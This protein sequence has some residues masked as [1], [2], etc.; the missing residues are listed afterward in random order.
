MVW[1]IAQRPG[2]Y[3][4]SRYFNQAEQD[5]LTVRLVTYIGVKPKHADYLN[6]HDIE[7]RPFYRKQAES[8][9]FHKL[10][11]STDGR[12]FF[13][14]IRPARH[15]I[16]EK[17]AIGGWIIADNTLNIID[18]EEVF[19]TFAMEEGKLK[20]HSANLFLQLIKEETLTNTTV[21]QLIE[22]PD[23]R[24]RYDKTRHEWRYDL[25]EETI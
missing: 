16:Y 5:S 13:Y 7:Y 23:N 14:V 21:P 3:E 25:M 2:I 17:R 18:V 8:F 10:L 24:C 1:L 20:Y 12:I 9:S 11:K 19:A 15:P 6:R 22:W 4:P